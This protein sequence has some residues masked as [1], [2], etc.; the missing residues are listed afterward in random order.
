M[1]ISVFDKYTIL[2]IWIAFIAILICPSPLH[3]GDGTISGS[4]GP[5]ADCT[6]TQEQDASGTCFDGATQAELD[7]KKVED[8]PSDAAIDEV[9]TG[10]GA[11]GVIAV[12]N[13]ALGGTLQG[14]VKVTSHGSGSTLTTDQCRGDLH[15]MTAAITLELPEVMASAGY[16]CCFYGTGVNALTIDPNAADSITLDGTAASNGEAIVS[17]GAAGD[18]ICVVNHAG[19]GW[20]TMGKAGTWAEET[21]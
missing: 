13:L 12:S 1:R 9:F 2:R 4:G 11:Q 10:D 17:S 21:P 15:I 14:N 7:G 3:A 18:K 5:V 6:G 8:S 19:T 16:N 20:I